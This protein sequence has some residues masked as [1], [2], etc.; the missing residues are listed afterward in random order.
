MKR[1]LDKLIPVRARIPLATEVVINLLAFYLT[2]VFTSSAVHHDLSLGIDAE[3]PF[4]PVFILFYFAAYLQWGLSFLAAARDAEDRANSF[5]FAMT[6]SKVIAAAFFILLPTTMTRPEVTGGGLFSALVR[7][8]YSVDSPDNLFPSIHCL[9]SWICFRYSLKRS[10]RFGF[11]Q[12]L[13]L[14]FTLGVF[15]STVLVKQHVAVDIIAGVAVAEASI[16]LT[17]AM[18]GYRV[19]SR[20]NDITV[21]KVLSYEKK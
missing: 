4:L 14:V 3:I 18:K 11:W 10:G 16:L 20:I 2:R 12:V 15:A 1:F 5:F 13:H 7:F 21:S 6:V 19:F 9:E 8:I 17:S